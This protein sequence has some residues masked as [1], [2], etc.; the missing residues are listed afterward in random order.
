MIPYNIPTLTGDELKYIK[1]VYEKKKFSGDG[2][3]TI[4][5]HRWFEQELN[6]PK[7]LLTTSCTHALEM[8]AILADI[9]AG[10]EVIMPSFTFTSTANAFVL[11]GAKI[12]F[13]EVKKETMNIDEEKLAPLINY[14]TKAIVVVH[15]AGVPCEM[16]KIKK[17]AEFNNL[18]IIEDAAQAILSKYKNQYAGNIGDFGCFS[19]HETKNIHC[20]EGGVL[21][22]NNP[23]YI[24]KAEI[25]REKGTDRS[26]FF[27][28]EIDKYSWVDM[29][30]SY[31]MSEINAAFLYGQL[32]NSR[33]IIKNRLKKWKKYYKL[34]SPLS[35]QGYIDLP[36]IP[37]NCQHNGHIFY[38]KCKDG[39][40]RDKLMS[41][42]Q[43]DGI[44]AI[45][46]YIPLHSSKAGQEFGL[47]YGIDY[48]PQESA[49]LLRLPLYHSLSEEQIEI[50]VKKIFLF[51]EKED[52]FIF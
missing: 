44:K 6:S 38:I 37:D 14:R 8:A 22:I 31:L 40:I 25:I 20:G 11:R 41:Y 1:Q 47:D 18:L 51:Y 39:Q 12:V 17:I 3:F 10:D 45:F 7:A 27:R 30:S 21:I 23:K 16:D 13:A 5:C 2:E 42:L 15:Y 48:T 28:G 33:K 19:F 43:K 24:E 36:T 49:R 9:K 34:L 50:I 32:L 4:K 52:V 26:K 35:V 29:G 46:H